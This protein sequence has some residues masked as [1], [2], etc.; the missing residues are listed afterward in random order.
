M[1]KE[2]KRLAK[3]EKTKS[4]GL[5]LYLIKVGILRYGLLF[6]FIW[7]F[8]PPIIDNEFTFNLLDSNIFIIKLIIFGIISP[9][10]GVLLAYNRWKKLN[11]K[12]QKIKNNN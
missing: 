4:K 5:R 1:N 3:W 12:M 7:A 10:F 8:L 11:G 2:E 6:Y 9:L